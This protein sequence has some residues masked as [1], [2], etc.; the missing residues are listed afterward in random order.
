MN[1]SEQSLTPLIVT[2][3]AGL[4]VEQGMGWRAALFVP[5]FAMLIMAWAYARVTQ[6][7][8]QGNASDLRAAGFNP[9]GG[10]RGGMAA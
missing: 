10:K 2:A 4:G 1:Q 5:G 3:L 9:E 8:P 7:T 6:N